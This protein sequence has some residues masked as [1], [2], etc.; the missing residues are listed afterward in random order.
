MH[1]L[2]LRA[3]S[4]QFSFDVFYDHDLSPTRYE[5]TLKSDWKMRAPCNS[6][7]LFVVFNENHILLMFLGPSLEVNSLQVSIEFRFEDGCPMQ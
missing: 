6:V 4:K 3:P 2:L 7:A 1:D 5:F